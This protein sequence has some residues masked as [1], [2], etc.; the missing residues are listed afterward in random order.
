MQAKSASNVKVVDV[1]HYQNDRGKIDW[2]KVRADG[3][4][5][6]I[7]KATEGGSGIDLKFSANATSAPA[8]GLKVGYYHY[9]HPELNT[10]ASEAAHF[11]KAVRGVKVHFPHAL[12]VE[13]AASKVPNDTLTAWCIEWLETVEELTGHP[14]MIY[15]GASF[16]RSH[17]GK[18][19]GKWPLWV[20]H[21]GVEKP[22]DNTTWPQWSLFQ[23]TSSG[24]VAGISGNVDVNAMERA[25]FDKYS[26][27]PQPTAEDSVKVV[28]NDELVAYGRIIDGHVYLPLRKL[29]EALGYNVEWRA[30]EASP[31]I[32]GKVV[33]AFKLIN[34]TTYVGIRSAAERLGGEV[35]FQND[36]KKVYFYKGG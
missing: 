11:A 4:A 24:A 34:G 28:V 17:L 1:S 9:A 27:V 15:T 25:F 7:I 20:A 22:L 32:D 18:A 29:G 8:I 12:D 21:Y 33:S 6:V 16:A 2:S 5:G 26:G 30:A 35:S 10:A 31:Y 13:G 3:V 19:L 14:T 36:T 23:Y